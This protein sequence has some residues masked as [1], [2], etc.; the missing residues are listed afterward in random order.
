MSVLTYVLLGYG[1]TVCH[2]CDE[3]G[4]KVP[5]EDGYGFMLGRVE[6]LAPI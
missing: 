5:D 3:Y 4:A 1:W 2:V 6:V